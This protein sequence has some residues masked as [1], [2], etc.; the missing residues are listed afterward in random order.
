MTILMNRS[1]ECLVDYYGAGFEHKVFKAVETK[2]LKGVDYT[3]RNVNEDKNTLELWDK[4]GKIG[5]YKF[6]SLSQLWNNSVVIK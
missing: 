6:N 1:I 4:H 5:T 3:V 2:F